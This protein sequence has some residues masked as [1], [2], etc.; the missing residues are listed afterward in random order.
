MFSLQRKFNVSHITEHP[1]AI[2]MNCLSWMGLDFFTTLTSS[3]FDPRTKPYP[4]VYWLDHR[5]GV[6]YR[7]AQSP[8]S[9]LRGGGALSVGDGA[10]YSGGLP[11]IVGLGGR[12]P[13][14]PSAP[15][16]SLGGGAFR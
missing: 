2:C 3:F 1:P 12:R 13:R 8:H 11:A 10:T 14:G 6:S 5:R 16:S 9:P 4:S 15:P 7:R